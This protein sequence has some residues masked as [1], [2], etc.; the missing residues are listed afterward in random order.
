MRSFFAAW[1]SFSGCRRWSVPQQVTPGL[2]GEP[3][4]GGILRWVQGGLWVPAPSRGS[5]C[6]WTQS[7][8]PSGVPGA[9]G[10]RNR[11]WVPFP[12]RGRVETQTG[13][14]GGE[15]TSVQLVPPLLMICH[16]QFCATISNFVQPSPL[17]SSKDELWWRN[18][19]A[20]ERGW[21]ELPER[22][23]PRE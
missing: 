9:F 3:C 12:G 5:R 22:G 18:G 17:A 14:A 6:F 21:R 7:P 19:Q 1:F 20:R 11:C 15:I 13:T 8:E 10:A 23:G 4:P 16:G 2:G